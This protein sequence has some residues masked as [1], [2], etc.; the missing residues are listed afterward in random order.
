MTKPPLRV[1][2]GGQDDLQSLSRALPHDLGAE[3]QV[4]GAMMLSA[5]AV[6]DAR[7]VLDGSE[8]YRPAHQE[9]WQAVCDL[10]DRGDPCEPTAVAAEL[11]PRRSPRSAAAPTCTP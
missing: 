1:V 6:T 3:R 2:D 9:I 11:G 7:E 5:R 10:A 4:L 8:F